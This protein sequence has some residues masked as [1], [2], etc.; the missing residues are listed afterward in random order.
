M[1]LKTKP[2]T[3]PNSG[4]QTP[5]RKKGTPFIFQPVQKVENETGP[6]ERKRAYIEPL[7]LTPSPVN[8]TSIWSNNV[9]KK[10]DPPVESNKNPPEEKKKNQSLLKRRK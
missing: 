7:V 3:K 6:Q 4:T 10:V 9:T 1:S 5:S 2:N 8:P